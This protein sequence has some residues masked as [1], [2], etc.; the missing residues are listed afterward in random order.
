MQEAQ[1]ELDKLEEEMYTISSMPS[2]IFVG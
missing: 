1:V 2:E